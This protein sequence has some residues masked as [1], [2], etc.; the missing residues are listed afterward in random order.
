MSMNSFLWSLPQTLCLWSLP[1]FLF[2]FTFKNWRESL[3]KMRA[4]A[5]VLVYLLSQ[6]RQNLSKKFKTKQENCVF[7][8][9]KSASFLIFPL[10]D[11]QQSNNSREEMKSVKGK[12]PRSDKNIDFGNFVNKPC[13]SISWTRMI[14]D[15]IF[16]KVVSMSY[17][18]FLVY[19]V[20]M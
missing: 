15:E 14:I 11:L 8:K 20:Q 1:Q 5:G 3:R 13:W 10:T 7:E 12:S 16:F 6:M 2:L 17:S 19:S 18:Q 9:S 4:L